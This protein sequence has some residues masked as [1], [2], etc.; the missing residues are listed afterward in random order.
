MLVKTLQ[1]FASQLL[2]MLISVGD[3][4]LL[5]AVLLR[6]WPTDLFADWTTLLAW[7]GLLGL[8]DAGFGIFVGNRLQ[9][10]M[11]VG[12][13]VGF[14]RQVG[15]AAFIYAL[16]ALLMVG[17][18]ALLAV[19][20]S[21][22]PFVSVHLLNSSEAS[23]VLFWLG[24][25]QA[26]QTAKSAF[27][28]IYRAY[29]DYSRGVIIDSVSSLCI[30][31]T[32]L[33]V[34]LGGAGPRV[35]ALSYISAQ[36]LFAWGILLTDLKRRYPTL[37]LWPVPPS[38]LELRDAIFA[39]RWYALTYAAPTMWLQAPVL[40]LSALGLSGPVVVTFVLHRTL[41]NFGRNFVVM[42]SM[43]AG[44]ELTPHVHSGDTKTIERGI[45]FLGRSVAAIGG[46]MA[47]GMLTFGGS[48][49]QL[50]TGKSDLFDMATLFWLVLP[51]IVIAPAI[52]LFYLAHLA[53]IPKQLAVVQVTQTVVAIALAA[54]LA[55]A[56]GAAGVAF[57]MA[58]GEIVSTGLVLPVLLK[59]RLGIAY[60]RHAIQCAPIALAALAWSGATGWAISFA[61][62]TP[63]WTRLFA[64][65]AAWGAV[66][67]L[68]I[69]SLLMPAS[70]QKRLKDAVRAFWVKRTK[71]A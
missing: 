57:A 1:N 9:K 26:V 68:P 10:T 6:V 50:W 16:L 56:F 19:V 59:R 5:T 62:G 3:R 21:V 58:I 24:V 13:K 23:L 37:R 4:F 52:P 42:L 14:Q 55:A 39:M 41:V 36:L 65:L 63:D 31:V 70:Q 8:A 25:L 69:A 32:A 48:L 2:S 30:V 54:P 22:S 33:A 40:L 64:C 46:V 7:S 67:F 20:E 44:V 29:G 45:T 17:A 34:A 66:T 71:E 28:Q 38:V 11:G 60:W 15:T 53:D 12:D 35:L 51:A 27:T 49:V 61:I 47:A 18:A 43:S